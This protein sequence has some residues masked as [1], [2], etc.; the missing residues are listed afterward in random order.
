MRKV[1]LA[2]ILLATGVGQAAA[3]P[4]RCKI[5]DDL[6]LTGLRLPASQTAVSTR[7]ALKILTVGGSSTAGLVAKGEEYTYP[8]QLSA[9]LR[10]RFPALQVQVV[11][12]GLLGGSTRARVDRL[13]NDL[14][15]T[16]PDLVIWA[17]GSTEAGLSEDIEAFVDSLR[18]GLVILH[19]AGADV[20]MIDL[21]WAPS[22]AR[23]VNLEQYNSA[24]AGVAAVEDVPVLQRSELMRRWNEDGTLR[25]D[26]PTS[27]AKRL[28]DIRLLFSCIAEAL[29]DGI[30]QAV[31]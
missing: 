28:T 12:R 9:R 31:Q 21:Q 27:P 3:D 18:E 17:P 7:K 19:A 10:L 6:A 14:R 22:I 5:P 20:I 2:L 25:F 4:A 23:V 29:A 30:G 26:E 15:D 1:V 24:I 13:A 11:N 8:A 16:K